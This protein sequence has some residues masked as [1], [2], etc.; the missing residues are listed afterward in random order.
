[1]VRAELGLAEMAIMGFKLTRRRTGKVGGRGG[2]GP[3]LTVSITPA[4][5]EACDFIHSSGQCSKTE[6]ITIPI[7]Q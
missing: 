6:A 1:V 5:G 7:Y 2:G 3:T 4:V